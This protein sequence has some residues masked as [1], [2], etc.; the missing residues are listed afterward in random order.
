[1]DEIAEKLSEIMGNPVAMEKLKNIASGFLGKSNDKPKK[2]N[3]SQS[4]GILNSLNSIPSD[5][6]QK[7]IGIMPL[8]N[9]INRED[10]NTRLLNSLRPFLSNERCKKLDEAIKLMQIIKILPLIKNSGIIKI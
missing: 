10:D 2:E 1:M 8:L 5:T 7:I 3:N 9:S 4:E 6:M